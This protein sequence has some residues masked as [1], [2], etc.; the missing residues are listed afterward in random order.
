MRMC[1]GSHSNS[2]SK[3]FVTSQRPA[4]VAKVVA[5][6]LDVAVHV[7]LFRRVHELPILS[8]WLLQ[9]VSALGA[10]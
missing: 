4:T 8:S 10:G 2:N 7:F 3:S 5:A 9:L 1:P 6:E